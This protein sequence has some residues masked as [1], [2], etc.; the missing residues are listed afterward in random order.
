LHASAGAIAKSIGATPE[1]SKPTILANGFNPLSLASSSL[2][3][4]NEEAPSL[5]F[6]AFAAVIEPALSKAGLKVGNL[7]GAYF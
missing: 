2:I 6:E 1:S 5:I 3:K 7:S 4:I